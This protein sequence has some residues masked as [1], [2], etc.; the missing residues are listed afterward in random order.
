MGAEAGHG[1]HLAAD[2]IDESGADRCPHLP[3]RE[4]PASG[5]APQLRIGRDGEV[6]LGDADRQPAEADA[7]VVVELAAGGRVVLDA[8]GAVHLLGDRLDLLPQRGLVGVEELELRGLLGGLG[9]GFRQLRASLASLGEVVADRRAGAAAGG[10]LGD[11]LVL[12][13]VV[14]REGVDRHHR[15]DAVEGDVLDLLLE[16]RRAHVDLVRVLRQ[17]LVGERSAGDDLV[18]ARVGLQGPDRGDEHGGVGTEPGVAALDVEELLGPDVGAEAGLGDEEVRG[19]DADEVAHDR[20]VAVGDVPERAG[21]N[22]GRRVLQCL[23]QVGLDRLPHDDRHRSARPEG[24]GRDRLALARV[25]H[26]DAIEPRPEVLE[27]R[28]Q[29]Q[30]RHH[31]G[32]R[33]DVEARLAGGAVVA[34]TETDGDVAQGPVVDVHHPAPGDVV[35]I[36]A[37]LVAM[38]E[39]VVDHRRQH[40]VGGGD[41]VH[42]A[43]QMEV[44][45]LHRHHLAVAAAGGPTLDAERRPHGGLADGDGRPPPDVAERLPQPHRGRRL[46]L[47]QGSRGDGA[48]DH[49]TGPG[50]VGELFDRLQL[51]LGHAVA[52]TLEEVFPDPHLCRDVAQRREACASGDLEI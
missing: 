17:E 44:E 30:H 48:D 45:G 14:C 35:D 42:V 13:R 24:F 50:A 23:E 34:R 8:V 5:R 22:D 41:G 21:V 47:S 26:H 9:H 38:V 15:A 18:L 16:V 52:V 43:G 6:R 32:R 7:L 46:A 39:V 36:D 4:N 40:V 25:R 19:V 11:G 29:G 20:R 31:L 1:P 49:V 33:G 10:D 28:R 51:D 27:G 12:G 3:H 37:E 2:G